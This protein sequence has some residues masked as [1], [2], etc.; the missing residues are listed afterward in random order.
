MSRSKKNTTPDP[1][2]PTI[3]PMLID[4]A[5]QAFALV[6]TEIEAVPADA[7]I[8]INVD[9][10]RAARR[11][12]V[13][14]ERV[15]PLLEDLTELRHFDVRMVRMLGTYA[16]A[17]LHTHELVTEGGGDLPPL[18]VLLAEATPLREGLLRTA[19]LLAHYELV[20]SERVATIRHGHGH[21]DTA[22]DLQALGRL[23]NELWPRVHDKVVATRAQVD[24]ALT[25]SAKLHK[26]LALHEVETDPL[27]R[28]TSRRHLRAQAYALFFRAYEET[29]RGVTFL[30]WYEGD[31]R[32]IVPSLYPRK[33]RRPSVEASEDQ[34][35]APSGPSSELDVDESTPVTADDPVTDA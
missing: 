27:T 18:P 33:P 31:A 2:T 34:T 5:S 20:S 12:L 28:H 9:I 11:G 16:L 24:R 25:L 4:T 23:F 21:A 1:F 32:G 17:L 13:A 3:D 7:L 15:E 35:G 8:A 22:D 19:E 14:A 30:R 6:R 26:A 29:R 10:S